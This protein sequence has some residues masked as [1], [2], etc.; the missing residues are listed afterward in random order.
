MENF[1][2]RKRSGFDLNQPCIGRQKTKPEVSQGR[3]TNTQFYRH[4]HSWTCPNSPFEISLFCC[5]KH[6]S[7]LVCNSFAVPF[8][9]LI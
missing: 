5:H 8:H 2:G 9:P 4:K 7:L 6:G 3:V 1:E